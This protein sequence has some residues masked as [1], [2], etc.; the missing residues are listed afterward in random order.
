[1]R[2]SRRVTIVVAALVVAAGCGRATPGRPGGAPA[3]P[4]FREP[5]ELVSRNGELKARL[6]VEARVVRLGGRDV[7]AMTYNGA[8]MPPTLR[9]RPGDR[10]HLTLE[11]RLDQYTNLHT[12]GW[13]VSP[14]GNSDNV[15]L[16]VKP[17]E[18]FTYI[19][20]LPKNLTPGT[21]WYRSHAHP[22][23]ET[24]V[25]AGLSGMIVIDGL[26]QYLP[27]GLRN[28]TE[29]LIALKDFQV[30]GNAVPAIGDATR[31]VNGLV[32]PAI[33]IRPGETQ[34]W[35][36]ANISANTDY[37][38]RLRGV[39]FHVLAQDANPVTEV[40][41]ADTLQIPPG[42]RFDVLVQGPPAGATEL[43]A[44]PYRTGEDVDGDG[45]GDA[46]PERTLATLV[47]AGHP[48]PRAAIP[49]K[50]AT[51]EDLRDATLAEQR[52][53]TLSR[54]G[55][56][57]RFLINGKE[58]DRHRIDVQARLNTVQ[59]WRVVNRSDQE[60]TLHAH[61]NDF[62]VMS[63]N[64]REYRARNWQDTVRLPVRGEV[65]LRL[66]F[67]DYLGKYPLHS[68]VLGHK[69]RGMMANVEVVP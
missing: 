36:L 32:N 64:G 40:W 29:R 39:R 19:Y 44:L 16:R 9:L 4:A 53:I 60:Q 24:Q 56:T 61:V 54:D 42:S 31:T 8:Y 13:H 41:S 2:Q 55:R 11:N 7:R 57:N 33:P 27:L 21:Y 20:R 12:H 48:V 1:M 26:D 14:S 23:S 37:R 52:T 30:R 17:G 22:Y 46:Q 45:D 51:F 5:V 25:L 66:R 34:L 49:E 38:V 15:Y 59:E 65:V 62:Q 10:L 18:T 43:V 35:R 28:V 67:S 63:V 50:F 47:S 58:F 6:V 3:Q 69:D 68:S